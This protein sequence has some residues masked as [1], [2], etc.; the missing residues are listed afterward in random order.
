MW[1]DAEK[2]ERKI[3]STNKKKKKK[4][5]TRNLAGR[6]GGDIGSHDCLSP[7]TAT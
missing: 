3:K 5:D 4:R 6:P 2:K 7:L 1:K